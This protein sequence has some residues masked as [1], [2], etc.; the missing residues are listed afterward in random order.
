MITLFVVVFCC[1][2]GDVWNGNDRYVIGIPVGIYL[3]L[4]RPKAK[5]MISQIT[6]ADAVART[7]SPDDKE[8]I[9]EAQKAR[10]QLSDKTQAFSTSYAFLFLGYKSELY[11]WEIVVLARKGVLSLIGVAFSTDPRTQVSL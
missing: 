3:I 8:S 11:L 4:S 9:I 1:V 5:H 2:F 7:A 10:G 6:R